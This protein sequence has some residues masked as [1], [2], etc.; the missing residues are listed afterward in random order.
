MWNNQN[1]NLL[2]N[3]TCCCEVKSETGLWVGKDHPGKQ[4][5]KMPWSGWIRATFHQRVYYLLCYKNKTLYQN[6]SS[7]YNS[8]YPCVIMEFY[9]E[10]Q[11]FQAQ[12]NLIKIIRHNG[13]AYKIRNETTVTCAKSGRLTDW[14]RVIFKNLLAN[15]GIELA[16][17]AR[18]PNDAN[19]QVFKFNMVS[20]R[21]LTKSLL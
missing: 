16:I 11:T 3:P 20:A 14:I 17:R 12:Q 6:T 2:P 10:L 9:N 7:N 13:R 8:F 21:T 4:S 15:P 1:Q 19:F 5:P 18:V